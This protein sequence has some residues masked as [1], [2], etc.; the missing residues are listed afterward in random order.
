MTK[1]TELPNPTRPLALENNSFFIE[2]DFLEHAELQPD[3]TALRSSFGRCNYRELADIS[4]RIARHLIVNGIKKNDRVVILSD[5]NPALVY[6]LLG[7]LR[8]GA[9]FNIAD[10]AY[11]AARTVMA[12]QLIQPQVLLVCGNIALP[13]ALKRYFKKDGVKIDIIYVPPEI[14]DAVSSFKDHE[15]F[16]GMADHLS[17][18]TAYITFTSGS[19]GKPKGIITTHAPLPHFIKWHAATHGLT[20]KDRFSLL[21]GLSH[22]PLLRDIFTPLSIGA[23]L[24]I[25]DEIINCDPTYLAVWMK[26]NAISVCHLTPAL[27]EVIIAGAEEIQEKLQVLRYCFWGGD[28]L[29]RKTYSRV[30]KYA[31]NATQV[32]FYGATETPQ[33]MGY[34]TIPKHFSGTSFPVGKGIADAQLLVINKAGNLAKVGETGEIWIRSPYLSTGYL[35]DAEETK[36]KFIP[37]PFSS[38]AGDT[39]YRTGD[40][41]RYLADG[42][43]DFAGRIDHQI[44]IRGFRIEPDEI[45][46][47]IE[48]FEGVIRAVV[49]AKNRD[50]SNQSKFL[51]AYF[52]TDTGRRIDQTKL[53]THMQE[54]LPAYMIPAYV[55]ELETFPL[56]PNGK[57]DLQNLPEPDKELRDTGQYVAPCNLKEVELSRIW[58]EVLGIQKVGVTDN[59]LSLGGDSLSSLR[60][61]VKMKKLGIPSGIARGI[62]QG[63]C[64]REIVDEECSGSTTSN[65][66]L[67]AE[68]K[69]NLLINMVRGILLITVISD[70]WA[71]GLLNKIVG[72]DH[73][74]YL[75]M[76]VDPFFNIATP[77]FAFVFGVNLGYVFYTK[78][79]VNAQQTRKMLFSGAWLLLTGNLLDAVLRL[80]AQG[81]ENVDS[82]IF[83]SSFFSALLYYAL[84]LL[85][86]P[87][88]FKII[89]MTKHELLAC[90]GLMLFFYSSFHLA[91]WL[92]LDREQS[93]FL[94]L[95]RLMLV[96]KFNYF[97]MSFGAMGGLMAGIYLKKHY[98]KD[99]TLNTLLMGIAGI[100]IGVAMLYVGTGTLQGLYNSDDMQLW[101][102]VF[103]SSLVLLLVAALSS[104]I[105]SFTSFPGSLRVFFQTIGVVGQCTFPLF[106]L[107]SLVIPCKLLLVKSGLQMWAALL[108]PFLIFFLIS[109]WLMLKLYNLYYGKTGPEYMNHEN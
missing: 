80:S 56:L 29:S 79:K 30:H 107:H 12:I 70:H 4:H 81:W 8:T 42:N 9:I 16:D 34:F 31:P 83:F 43:V 53:M 59:F 15:A 75:L 1:I 95:C 37:N 97:N 7:V 99:Y 48:Q 36:K 85:T 10:S 57:I 25:P 94:Q 17:S 49:I 72:Q 92:L 23:T 100:S 71:E 89:A 90:T 63:K 69:T 74:S 68:S 46:R 19:T 55:V 44:K 105:R 61:L 45:A 13:D 3:A 88:W 32:N 78:S 38:V 101:R 47:T 77:G 5:R 91:E 28:V 106:V 20:D 66:E 104:M 40:I 35:N 51:I 50:K 103:Y 86:A 26:L 54:T 64:I 93:G 6:A 60:A 96:A 11:P 102:W 73:L 58:Q 41:G 62:C 21:S 2:H 39:C 67:S 84:A 82:T 33:A 22:D 98:R 14:K 27:G 52:S 87:L 109:A 65:A 18:D 24:F 108:L 76:L